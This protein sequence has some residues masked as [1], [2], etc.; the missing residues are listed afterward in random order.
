M[1]PTMTVTYTPQ[2]CQL[3]RRASLSIAPVNECIEFLGRL[4]T[5]LHK[6]LP[7]HTGT[8]TIIRC[9]TRKCGDGVRFQQHKSSNEVWVQHSELSSNHRAVLHRIRSA[10]TLAAQPKAAP[11]T[12]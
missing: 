9:I 11:P 10:V 4:R 1:P 2:L 12:T 6:R 5:S 7:A 8:V 3:Q